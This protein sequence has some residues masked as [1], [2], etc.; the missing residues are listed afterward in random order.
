[1]DTLWKNRSP[2]SSNFG[3][4][5]KEG[6]VYLVKNLHTTYWS[7]YGGGYPCESTF[8]EYAK[9]LID[10]QN[11]SHAREGDA[12]RVDALTRSIRAMHIYDSVVVFE[13]GVVDRPHDEITGKQSFDTLA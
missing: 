12:L 8:I 10:A 2:R 11:E 13:K 4:F 6:G 5:V 9:N 3:P 7:E 1:M